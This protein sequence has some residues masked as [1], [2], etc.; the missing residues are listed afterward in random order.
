MWFQIL[1][2]LIAAALLTKAIV[3]LIAP[4]RFYATRRQQYESEALPPKLCLPAIVV[5]GLAIVAWFATIFHFQPWS[6]LVT[7]FLSVIS[8]MA[9]HHL[10]FWTKH[11]QAMLKVV[12]N[13][14][15]TKFDWLL[16]AVGF[17]FLALAVFVF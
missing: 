9:I 17:G 2:Y 7:G 14:K 11:R 4:R 13:P 8:V 5:L 1:S 3:A 10:L 16:L 15:V 12:T 6:W